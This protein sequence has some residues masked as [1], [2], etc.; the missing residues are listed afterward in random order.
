MNRYLI[1]VTMFLSTSCNN[2]ETETILK[3]TQRE[4]PKISI[5][6]RLSNYFYDYEIEPSIIV[7][8]TEG[9]Q[10]SID[11]GN[12]KIKWLNTEEETK[13]KIDNDLFTLKDKV[14]LNTVWGSKDIVDFANNWDEIKL[15]KYDQTELIAIGMSFKPCTGLGCSVNYFLFYDP[16]SKTKNFFG[17]FRS[18]RKMALYHF[19]NEVSYVST[20]YRDSANNSKVEFTYEL[21]SMDEK[22]QFS[23]MK[24]S[25]GLTY[26]IKHITFPGDTLKSEILEQNWIHKI[27]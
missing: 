9:N 17:Q 21:F 1:I 16:K 15:F 14:T 26:Q 7:N 25:N 22:G 19:G 8:N 11:L 6:D 13:I 27:K 3:Q 24:N 23:K 10:T 5:H 12:H 4:T 18:D 20:T 2:S